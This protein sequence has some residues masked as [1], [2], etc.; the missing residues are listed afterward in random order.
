MPNTLEEREWQILI[1][2]ISDKKCTPFLGAGACF[3]TLPTG[4]ELAHELSQKYRYP[5]D[6]GDD[7]ARVAQ[8]LAVE[9]E[10]GIFPKDQIVKRF[11]KIAPPNFDEP[12]EPHSVLASLPLPIYITTNYDDFMMKALQYQNRDPRRELCRWNERLKNHPSHF[13]SGFTPSVAEPVV[14]HLHGHTEV[15]DS[16]V[17]TEDDYLDFLISIS[18]DQD[19]L[20]LLIREAFAST[21]LL[22]M[23]YRLADWDFRVLFRSLVS[24]LNRSNA[25]SHVSVQLLPTGATVSDDEKERARR[26][27]DHYFRN[28]NIHVYWGACREFTADLK[29]RWEAL[30]GG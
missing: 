18:Q 22:F 26:F 20:P 12:N 14:F 5:L 13:D 30:N 24:Y 17:L 21:S 28:Q 6:G 23:G 2:R 27:F 10:D 7:L 25:R 4:G 1:D 3:G 8:F 15:E 16:M 11:A 9:Y 19:L 29:A